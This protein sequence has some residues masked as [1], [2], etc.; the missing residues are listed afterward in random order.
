MIFF[1]YLRLFVSCSFV[2]VGYGH[3]DMPSMCC[4]DGV[5]VKLSRCRLRGMKTM[6]FILFHLLPL[7]PPLLCPL[8]LI[9]QRHWHLLCVSKQRAHPDAPRTAFQRH[10]QG[11]RG[12]RWVHNINT[13]TTTGY[14]D[15]LLCA[16]GDVRDTWWW[17]VDGQY[18]EGRALTPPPSPPPLTR[19]WD[20]H[21]TDL[22]L[23]TEDGVLKWDPRPA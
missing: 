8:S 19:N 22:A 5:C 14:V 23:L 15:A 4:V 16:F 21:T 11:E 13:S 20:T 9:G 12:D 18:R 3:C 10:T 7:S 6:F 2:S 1:H 17:G